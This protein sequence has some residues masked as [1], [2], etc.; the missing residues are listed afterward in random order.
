[1]VGAKDTDFP[2]VL[3]SRKAFLQT[4]ENWIYPQVV[5]LNRYRGHVMTQER[6]ARETFPI[7]QDRL[8]V[9][10]PPRLLSCQAT[11]WIVGSLI[12]RWQTMGLSVRPDL[13]H[14]HF[15]NQGWLDAPVAKHLAVPQVVTFYGY[16]LSRLPRDPR[17][18]ARYA[19]LFDETK[20][21]T[22]EGPF[23]R[24]TLEALGC[25]T[26]KIRLRR[27]GIDLQT[28]PFV[29]RSRSANGQVRVLIAGRFAE[30]KGIPDAL[31][32]VASVAKTHPEVFVTVIGDAQEK[33]EVEQA[34]KA[35]IL[36]CLCSGPLEGRSR[37]LGKVGFKEFMQIALHHHFFVQASRHAE[38][39]DS[40]GGA[41]VSLIQLAATGMP[42]VATQ[43]CDIP[44]IVHHGRTGLLTPERDLN[45]LADA[46][47][48]MVES[49]ERWASMGAAARELASERFDET[50]AIEMLENIYDE[51]LGRDVVTG[52][53]GSLDLCRGS[54]QTLGCR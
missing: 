44:E 31:N 19:A 38:C 39:G 34:Q 6:V 53:S 15:G 40:E 33:D 17:W 4:S 5:A 23:M 52:S 10:P 1:M 36:D 49:H 11:R 54:D 21:F 7:A 37:W 32:A 25:P 28:F 27:H 14:S 8:H 45:A 12:A 20:L 46:I 43:H 35:A 29:E 3:H 47:E 42:I 9:V 50:T 22:V 51:A 48:N 18:K 26:E 13:V 2:I 16:D 30:K 41:P 24:R